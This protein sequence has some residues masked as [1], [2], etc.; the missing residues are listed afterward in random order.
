[1]RSLAVRFLFFLKF[2]SKMGTYLHVSISNGKIPVIN[3]DIRER[4]LHTLDNICFWFKYIFKHYVRPQFII[5]I[6]IHKHLYSA[7]YQPSVLIRSL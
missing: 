2:L 4:R 3:Y 5:I 6:I 7:K 1:M